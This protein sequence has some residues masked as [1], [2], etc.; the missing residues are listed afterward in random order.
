[1][2]SVSIA[3]TNQM[4]QIAGW[5]VKSKTERVPSFSSRSSSPTRACRFAC[6]PMAGHNLLPLPSR[7]SDMTGEFA[8]TFATHATLKPLARPIARLLK[9]PRSLSF[10]HRLAHCAMLFSKYLPLTWPKP[11]R[12]R[13]R[14]PDAVA[15][16]NLP[17]HPCASQESGVIIIQSARKTT[18]KQSC[19]APGPIKERSG[20]RNSELP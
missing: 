15:S 20:A 4:A 3:L 5:K 17:H 6:Q 10:S 8:M 18:R 7:L 19:C 14:T 9:L 11:C 1:M 2:S 13:F 12:S 16:I